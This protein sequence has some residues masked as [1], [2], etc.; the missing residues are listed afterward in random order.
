METHRKPGDFLGFSKFVYAYLGSFKVFI[1]FSTG[2]PLAF[3]G[4]SMVLLGLKSIRKVND[5][6]EEGCSEAAA[7]AAAG[8]A[9]TIWFS[10]CFGMDG[11]DRQS[12]RTDIATVCVYN[13]V[14]PPAPRPPNT[15]TPRSDAVQFVRMTKDRHESWLVWTVQVVERRIAVAQ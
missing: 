4:L 3:I 12:A 13:I 15:P 2:F 14:W 8:A 5:S 10:V 1:S 11:T 9:S 7:G 6:R